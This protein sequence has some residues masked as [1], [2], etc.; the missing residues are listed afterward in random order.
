MD[1]LTM[2][3]IKLTRRNR[4]GA[5]GTQK[6]RQRGLTAIAAELRDLGYKLPAAHSLKT[7]HVGALV[8]HWQCR[9]LDA[10]TIRNRLT[11]LRW[12]AEK[13][14]K[15]NVV[16]RDN[17]AYGVG[18]KAEQQPN[19]AFSLPSAKL[20]QIDCPYVRASLR[21]QA[22]FGLRREEAIK[23]Q[24]R[25]AVR[26]HRIIL[27]GSWTKGGRARQIPLTTPQQHAALLEVGRLVLDEGSLI[28]HRL[29]YAQQ[30]KRY[31]HQTLNAGLR[32][33]HGLR[34]QYAQQR[35]LALTGQR[36]PLAGGKRWAELSHRERKLDIHARRQIALE[37]GHGRLA[38]TNIYLG[39][40]V[41]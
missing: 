29:S 22:A 34:H 8:E 20:A 14:D 18:L 16:E 7:K 4:D 6:N 1:N 10:A 2:D 36:C 40:A 24:P 9:E 30:L 32:N 28:P 15:A 19:R 11:W 17:R 41:Q 26:P 35:Y 3:L 37:L 33:T 5:Y 13:I 21:L 23:F 12:W 25:F 31:E 27:K 39:S 38:I